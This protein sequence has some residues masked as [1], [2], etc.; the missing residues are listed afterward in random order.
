MRNETQKQEVQTEPFD[1][2]LNITRIISMLEK[3]IERKARQ[4]W[5][6]P[7]QYPETYFTMES[8]LRILRRWI[9]IYRP[10]CHVRAFHQ[11]AALSLETITQLV[12][13]FIITNRPVK[14]KKQQKK[15]RRVKEHESISNSIHD[16][17]AHIHAYLETLKLN[18][19]AVEFELE[20][21]LVNAFEFHCSRQHEKCS[22]IAVSKRGQKTII[23]PFSNKSDYPCLVEDKNA[24]R[25]QV[26][27]K[28]QQL[29][30]VDGHADG[31]NGQKGYYLR[32]FRRI[33]R[34]TIVEG[35]RQGIF[36]IRMVECIN[37]SQRFSLL[38][39]FLP[40][41]K[42]FS[43]DIIGNILRGILLFA[44]SLNSAFED[45]KLTGYA[46]KSK[47]TL[48]NWIAWMGTHHPATILTRA[49]AKSSG[50]FQED[51][52]FEKE[53]DLRTYT[54]AMVDCDTLLVWHL[55][56]VDRVDEAT[57]CAS[58]E[59][60][61]ERIDFNLIGVTKDKWK[62]STNALKS[63]FHRLWI[64]FCH[65]HCLKKFRLALTEYQKRTECTQKEVKRLYAKFKEILD[66]STS[67]INFKVK[68]KLSKEV[69]FAHPIV[70]AVINEIEKNAK[71]YT[72]HKKRKGIRK[73][74]S[75]VDN[76]LKT[77]KRKLKQ[78]ESFR[79][80]D[81][82][83]ILFSAIANVRNFVPFMS[84]AK[85]AHKSPFMLA[86]GQTHDLPWIQVMN[87]HNAFLFT[88]ESGK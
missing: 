57:L 79:D 85:N 41:E 62:A 77:V 49:K 66:S 38:P 30:N 11:I 84:G 35:G 20:K 72:I 68:I 81:W 22:K 53:P 4:L 33:P 7:G 67:Q 48:L 32:G 5:L 14:G 75:L 51:E 2:L 70:Y 54:V 36:P 78:V 19:T 37:C 55:D 8:A 24:F 63:V 74:T 65:R 59:K 42:H 64:G 40:R 13:D 43:I 46:L 25:L 50:Y 52:G 47:Q 18:E 44:H 61:V 21:A 69:A 15:S 16:M 27:D 6:H 83:S 80:R 29:C 60:F 76:F 23:F 88:D 3:A 9:E 58:F 31:C 1:C 86:T 26:V 12:T 10:F 39:S 73:T 17:L 34:K 28:I 71:H 45:M 87:I 82:T 56:Y